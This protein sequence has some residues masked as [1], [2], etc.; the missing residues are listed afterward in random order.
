MT[1][2]YIFNA[3]DASR[4][5]PGAGY[6]LSVWVNLDLCYGSGM[7]CES[8][9]VYCVW[10]GL[11]QADEGHTSTTDTDGSFQKLTTTCRWNEEQA[12]DNP[13]ILFKFECGDSNSRI[14]EVTLVGPLAQ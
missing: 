3:L 13:K 1:S 14:D 5:V 2:Y 6:D 11:N 8:V 9:D 4:I 12:G 10:G 7:G